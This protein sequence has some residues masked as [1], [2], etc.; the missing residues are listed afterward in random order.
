MPVILNKVGEHRN[1]DAIELLVRYMLGSKFYW[2]YGSRGLIADS[3][4]NIIQGFS[5]TKQMY[6]K[7]DGKQV[8]HFIIGT[9]DEGISVAQ[10]YYIA[11]VAADYFFS[12]GYQC[13]YVIH[14]MLIW[15]ERIRLFESGKIGGTGRMIELHAE[16]GTVK[17][18]EEPEEIHSYSRWQEYGYQVKKGEKAV[19]T[20]EI[21]KY[22]QKKEDSDKDGEDAEG[23]ERV[24]KKKA[25]FFRFS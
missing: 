22:A 19:S 12:Q 15:N 17:K 24:F 11:E 3:Q 4:E 2:R 16:D 1:Q 5:Y 10:L 23:S 18:M 9:E 25:F 13:F 20:I 7:T 14:E 6:D 21:W 8:N